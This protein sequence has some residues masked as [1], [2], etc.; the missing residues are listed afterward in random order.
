MSNRDDLQHKFD[1]TTLFQASKFDKQ[2]Q[3]S[4]SAYEQFSLENR[5][6]SRGKR[7]QKI[8]K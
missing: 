2:K 5:K 6:I 8:K 7:P 4:V 3:S 1:Q